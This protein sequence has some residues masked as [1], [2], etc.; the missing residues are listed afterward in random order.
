[1][2]ITI[3]TLNY[4]GSRRTVELLKS[5]QEQTLGPGSRSSLSLRAHPSESKTEQAILDFEIIVIDNASEEADFIRLQDFLYNSSLTMSNIVSLQVTRNR[6]NLGF[7]GGNNVAIR[8]ALTPSQ[9]ISRNAAK[10]SLTMCE[11]Q[12]LKNGSDWVVLLNN[13]IWVERDFVERLRAVLSRKGGVIGIPLIEGDQTAYCGQIQWLKPTLPHLTTS[14]VV[15]PQAYAIGGAVAIHKDVFEKIGFLDDKY[16][17]YFE[18]ADF[19]VR[20]RKA[21]FDISI[22]DNLNVHHHVSS[23]AK[24]LGSSLLMRY[25]YRNALYFNLKNGPWYIKLAVWPWSWLIIIKQLGKLAI[26]KNTKQSKAILRGV[27]DFY[28]R[29][30]GKI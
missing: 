27:T 5:L 16:F 2:R 25:H 8:Q 20:A 9:R 10:Q 30:Y 15:S 6:E 18:D 24:K 26:N 3:I 17:L 14:E 29:R 19:S 7:S 4:N 22:A 1:M 21:G 12:A 23:S 28:K 13:D 11:G